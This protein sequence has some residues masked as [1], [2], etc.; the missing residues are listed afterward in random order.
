LRQRRAVEWR[1]A[2]VA[3]R[4]VAIVK[5]IALGGFDQP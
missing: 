4:S 1:I 2:E 5:Q 3:R